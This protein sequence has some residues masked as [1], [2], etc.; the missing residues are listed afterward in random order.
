M[1]AKHTFKTGFEI[2]NKDYTFDYITVEDNIDS[3]QLF[4]RSQ[5][6]TNL[7]QTYFQW[8]S[9]LSEKWEINSGVHF[10]YFF[11]N[12][13]FGVDP[14]FSVKYS[15]SPKSNLALSCGLH[16]KPE[17]PS[18]Y[19]LEDIGPDGIQRNPNLGLPLSK[20]AHFVLGFN[21][22]FSKTLNFKAEIYYQHL[23]DIP[24]SSDPST[25]FTALNSFD[26]FDNIYN[27]DNSRTAMVGVGQGRN[28]GLELSLE[29]FFDKGYYYLLN[30]SLFESKYAG[31]DKKW[32]NTITST[33]ILFNALGGKEWLIGKKKK[34]VLGL[35]LK[36]AIYGGRRD[37]PIDL[38]AS[39][40][41]GY[42]VEY[43]DSFY[44][45]QLKPY[46]R[47]DLGI[48]YKI[49]TNKVTHTFLF[50]LQNVTNRFNVYNLYFDRV[51]NTLREERQNGFVP[52]MSYRLEFH[53]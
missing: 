38:D 8:K 22:R 24:V 45:I 31:V 28:Y 27:N 48:S 17:H 37:T 44:T 39:I 53:L 42:Q 14:R 13:T 10:I 32:Y 7:L 47:L 19:F 40:D 33:K 34:N 36:Y 50:D 5:G 1:S 43:P 3:L 4:V 30:T 25:G 20:A 21:Q 9:Y 49:N 41:A 46:S 35:N 2:K 26:V 15:F 51:S 6:N 23:F 29:K 11:L 16:S 18:T 12:N 52:F